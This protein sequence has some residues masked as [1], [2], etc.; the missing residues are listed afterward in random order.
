MKFTFQKLVR[1]PHLASIEDMRAASVASIWLGNFT[2]E[3]KLMAYVSSK[4]D[5]EEHF[6]F[7]MG[8]SDSPEISVEFE[9][10]GI[11]DL[12]TGFSSWAS[13]ID[14]AC[15]LA[16]EQKITHANCAVV[17]YFINYKALKF[18]P[19]PDAQLHFLGVI[20]FKQ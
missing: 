15:A 5:F 12:L 11:R 14:E 8:D 20:S 17:W 4:S 19:S 18:T 6:G 1:R 10:T 7:R 9:L 2:H 3:E 16:E 13:F